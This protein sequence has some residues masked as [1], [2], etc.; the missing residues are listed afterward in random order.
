MS[1]SPRCSAPEAGAPLASLPA[2]DPRALDDAL[3]A[4][5]G[6]PAETVAADLAA[7]RAA[8]A[9]PALAH[10]GLALLDLTTLEADD[11]PQRVRAL[12]HR[13]RQ[14]DPTDP[15]APA[16]AGLCTWPDLVGAAAAVLAG[17]GVAAVAVAGAFPH[18]R[19]TDAVAAAEVEHAR[20]AGADEIDVVL[21][22]GALRGAG[23]SAAAAR[24][25]VLRE[26]AGSAG[27]KVILETGALADDATIRQAGW[28]AVLAGAD[29]LKTSTGT[30]QPAATLEATRLL[31][32]IARD[33]EALTGRRIGVKP[34]GGI[35]TAEQAAA[36]VTLA[37]AVRGTDGARADRLR[38]GASSLLDELVAHRRG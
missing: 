36:L 19:T 8:A 27:L 31:L 33:G 38:L 24:L 29:V 18:A 22:R 14:P 30:L 20:C 28:I 1:R 35:R 5:P 16:V 25:A 15:A 3:H 2:M 9:D 11:T 13:A 21:D 10:A 4:H 12:A 7:A 6:D 23:P 37:R 17:S 32:E 26:A 34:A